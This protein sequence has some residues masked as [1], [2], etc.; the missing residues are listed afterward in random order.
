MWAGVDDVESNVSRTVPPALVSDL[1]A[2]ARPFE[3]DP[4]SVDG[5]CGRCG[6][7]GV[8]YP[9]RDGGKRCAGCFGLQTGW[10]PAGEF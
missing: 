7:L 5:T 2:R 4:P 8:V 1:L 10:M 6:Y 3:P 9:G